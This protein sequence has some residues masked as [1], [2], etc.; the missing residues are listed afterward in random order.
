LLRG[1]VLDDAESRAEDLQ[2]A[3]TS[4]RLIGTALGILMSSARITQD[5]AFARLRAASQTS[6]RKLRDVADEVVLTGALPD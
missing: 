5:E 6:N 3:L 2:R 4:N 1:V